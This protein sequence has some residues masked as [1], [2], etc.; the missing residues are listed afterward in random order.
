MST[1]T[2]ETQI[3]AGVPPVLDEATPS[4]VLGTKLVTPDGRAF[5]YVLAGASA[6]VTGNLLQSPAEA[7]GNQSRIVAAAAV[8]ATS[9]TTT[10]TVTV[11]A[12]QYAGGYLI[13]TGEAGTGRGEVYRIKS[14]PAATGAVCTFQLE[15]PIQVA[16]SSS[17]Q[18]DLVASPYSGVIQNPTT[19]SG[20]VVGVAVNDITAAQYGWIQTRGIS[21][22][23]ADGALTVGA[24]VVASNG[25]AGAVEVATNAS[26]E[27]QAPVGYA[28]TGV[29]TTE[30]GAVFLTID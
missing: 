18:V 1:Y 22:P 25:T 12:N 6:L 14:H 21:A 17:S 9:V 20:C 5:R 19:A 30:N 26:T 28:A 7:T 10:D 15:D 4:Q 13:P 24:L 2:G 3:F 16:L 23:L 27:A 29:A 11:T 8:G